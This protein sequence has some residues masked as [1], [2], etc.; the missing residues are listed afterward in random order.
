[1]REQSKKVALLGMMFALALV[2]SFFE[3]MLPP[4]PIAMPGVKLGLSNIVTMYALVFMDVKSAGIIALLKGLS[5][6]FMRGLVASFMSL[7]GGLV[8]VLAMAIFYVIFVKRSNF[9]K[10]RLLALAIVGSIFHNVGQLFVSC[11]VL[12][13]TAAF[14]YLPILMVSGIAMGVLTGTTLA[15]LTPY[16]TK[17]NFKN[18]KH[19]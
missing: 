16:F 17:L 13:T 10:I 18:E 4:L 15:V 11:L 8:S 2:L 9:S 14:A 19:G 5:V 1:M 6:L 3:Q 7:G 12:K